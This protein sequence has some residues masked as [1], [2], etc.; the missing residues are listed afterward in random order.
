M[1]IVITSTVFDR[2]ASLVFGTTENVFEREQVH[3]RGSVQ[4]RQ[5]SSRHCVFRC[6]K[7]WFSLPATALR[8]VTLAERAVRLPESPAWLLGIV[9][10]QSE[11]IPVISLSSF[12][13]QQRID[14]DL[15]SG[16]LLILN[17]SPPWAIRTDEVAALS[18]LE[19]SLSPS[20]QTL[21]GSQTGIVGTFTWGTHIARVLEPRHIL[22]QMQKAFHECWH[23]PSSADSP[24]SPPVGNIASEKVSS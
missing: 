20:S 10:L 5:T 11:F 15:T 3:A 8:E 22:A 9:H 24:I 18:D 12:I 1:P 19:A 2:Q 13:E 6:G 4:G 14:A 17:G 21:T 23:A 7:S 16:R